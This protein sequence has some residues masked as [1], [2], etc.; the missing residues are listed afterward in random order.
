MS[1]LTRLPE[2]HP[3]FSPQAHGRF[4]RIHL[5]VAPHCNIR[6][7]YCD[8]RWDCP[9]ESRPGVAS[10]LIT[11]EE[12]AE[13]VAAFADRELRL[14]VAGVAGPGELLAN[15]ETFALCRQ[16]PRLTLCISTNGLLLPEELEELCRCGVRTLTITINAI[17]P[18]A[19][20]QLYTQVCWNDI[21]LSPEE[22][23]PLLMEQQQWGLRLAVQSGLAVKVNT[24]LVPGVNEDEVPRIAALAREAGAAVMNI[25]PL[26][27]CGL[28]S[29]A[30][31]PTPELLSAARRTANAW[32]PQFTRCKQCRADTCGIP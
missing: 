30:A 23:I 24:V 12:A 18:A 28:L 6:C 21:V 22:G 15:P 17:R 26:I 2:E 16:F 27:P 19:A 25:T 8:R 20:A 11:P 31:P 1:E 5:P 29:R 14:R 13:R 4:A 10:A 3:C 9:N 32:L 7:A